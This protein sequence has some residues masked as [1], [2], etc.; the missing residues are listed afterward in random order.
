MP[1]AIAG[2]IGKKRLPENVNAILRVDAVELL[3]ERADQHHSPKAR[4]AA[5]VCP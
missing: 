5:S 2:A 3:I 1:D 4:M